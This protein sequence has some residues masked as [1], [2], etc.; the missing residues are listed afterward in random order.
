MSCRARKLIYLKTKFEMWFYDSEENT[1][2][3][4]VCLW[5]V[6]FNI[7]FVYCSMLIIAFR[8][9]LFIRISGDTWWGWSNGV[10]SVLTF[11]MWC[12]AETIGASI[13]R[14][15]GH[16]QV[17]IGRVVNENEK[18]GYERDTFRAINNHHTFFPF[19]LILHS[20]PWKS[21]CADDHL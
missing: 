14:R 6:V 13:R 11:M 1:E 5:F 20:S 4:I 8:E 18:E 21:N 9:C 10:L 17:K 2:R 12:D 19:L 16:L 15:R 3:K 7:I